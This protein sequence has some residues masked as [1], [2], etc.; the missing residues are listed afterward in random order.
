MNE[1]GEVVLWLLV[2]DLALLGFLGLVALAARKV[3]KLSRK[4]DSSQPSVCR[5]RGAR[6]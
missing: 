2:A 3:W 1:L 6:G 4:P 5:Q